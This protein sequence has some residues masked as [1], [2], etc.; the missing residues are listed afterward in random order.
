MSVVAALLAVGTIARAQAPSNVSS[1]LAPVPDPAPV[2]G[3]PGGWQA[4]LVPGGEPERERVWASA[5]YLLWWVRKTSVPALVGS[6]SA[7][8]V[9]THGS[10]LPPESITTVFGGE[11]IRYHGTSGVRLTVGGWLNDQGYL[12]VEASGF[13]LERRSHSF[14][15][16]STPGTVV[17]PLF[18]DVTAARITIITPVDPTLASEHA[19]L[20]T[21]ERIWGTEAN[22]RY[23][24]CYFARSPLDLLVGFRYIRVAD[25]LDVNS[26]TTFVGSGTRTYDDHFGTRDQFYGTQVGLSFD[27]RGERWNFTAVGKIAL[28]AV[29]EEANIDGSTTEVVFGGSTTT[30]PGG[31]LT[32]PGNMGHFTDTQFC[33]VPEVT[34]NLSYQVTQYLRA[35]VGYNLIYL[36][37]VHRT[38]EAIDSDVNP[39]NI[40]G[41]IV[42]NPTTVVQ[43]VHSFPDA[44]LTIQGLNF[45]LDFRY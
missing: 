24:L 14:D 13:V 2:V 15:V 11:D 23:N 17:G 26:T 35:F 30:F 33:A 9:A 1:P 4:G 40:R 22:A 37:Q 31:V 21:S 3:E 36:S 29:R 45:G 42:Q 25:D 32:G 18:N 5:E 43:P 12:G 44:D 20:S 39:S 6:V 7:A 8:D 38:G 19:G 10:D 28:G 41:L 16:N 34:L 27:C